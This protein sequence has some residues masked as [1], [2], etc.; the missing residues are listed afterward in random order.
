MLFQAFY[1][2]INLPLFSPCDFY[3]STS[4]D[5]YKRAEGDFKNLFCGIGE[6]H[7]GV[8]TI[9]NDDYS[10]SHC[11]WVRWSD[12]ASCDFTQTKNETTKYVEIDQNCDREFYNNQFIGTEYQDHLHGDH[13]CGIH[14][15]NLR[16]SDSG[17]WECKLDYITDKLNCTAE[18]SAWLVVFIH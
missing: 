2:C 13:L 18:G 16:P 14:A 3:V 12:N 6:Y 1:T 15:R 9:R 7:H 10:W 4:N 8:K 11:R 17:V 5:V